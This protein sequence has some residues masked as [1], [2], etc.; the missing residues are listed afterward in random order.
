[1]SPKQDNDDNKQLT[2]KDRDTQPMDHGRLSN[3]KK[4]SYAD[5]L[6]ITQ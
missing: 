4:T 3:M 2:R 5:R 6:A 1:M